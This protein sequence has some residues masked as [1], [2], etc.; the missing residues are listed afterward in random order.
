ML[1]AESCRGVW[2]G[3][4]HLSVQHIQLLPSASLPKNS[5]LQALDFI[6]VGQPSCV[7]HGAWQEADGL[8]WSCLKRAF[9]G[10]GLLLEIRPRVS[11]AGNGVLRKGTFLCGDFQHA[12]VS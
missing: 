1:G 3:T 5:H 12:G 2:R 9:L 7:G 8:H 11:A 10:L 6:L 4:E